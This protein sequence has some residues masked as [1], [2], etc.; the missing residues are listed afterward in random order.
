MG[1]GHGPI[2]CTLRL[3]LCEKTPPPPPHFTCVHHL[4]GPA[5]DAL[6]KGRAGV[7]DQDVPAAA[8]Q[9]AR[10]REA[11]HA[12]ADDDRICSGRRRTRATREGGGRT[13]AGN[14]GGQCTGWRPWRGD[15]GG[16]GAARRS[17]GS[18]PGRA[19]RT[20]QGCVRA[21]GQGA[22][23]ARCAFKTLLLRAQPLAATP[24]NARAHLFPE[25]GWPRN[26]GARS[27]RGGGRAA[28]ACM[29]CAESATAQALDPQDA[30]LSTLP[31]SRQPAHTSGERG[32]GRVRA[33]IAALQRAR[34]APCRGAGRQSERHARVKK[35]GAV[36]R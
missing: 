32:G 26:R 1:Q 9:G 31:S 15:S 34:M 20:F 5:A 11:D 12:R 28:C 3:C 23:L 29:W 25:R 18:H 13:F 17:G 7:Q 36:G 27:A 10:G 8:G 30:T 16:G 21:P 14:G 24:P 33:C 35:G 19:P 22:P 4:T 6:A 2:G